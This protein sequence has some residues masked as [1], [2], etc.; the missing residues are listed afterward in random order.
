MKRKIFLNTFLVT[1]FVFSVSMIIT[2]GVLY[3]YYNQQKKLE[4]RAEASY[5]CA[6]IEEN[7]VQMLE[8]VNNH[9]QTEQ[10]FRVTLMSPDGTVLYDSMM[11]SASM[12][13]HGQRQEFTE[14]VETGT[15]ESVR[16][17]ETL[18]RRTYNYA[19]A[20]E[21]GNVLRISGEQFTLIS[22]LVNMIYPMVLLILLV[23]LLSVIMAERLSRSVMEP[24]NNLEVESPMERDIYPELR[25]LVQRIN[26]Q[27]RQLHQQMTELREEHEKQDRMRREFTANV[28]HELKTPLTSISGYAEILGAGIVHGEDV[29][30]F[31]G[32]IYDEAQR[33]ITL[34]G[35]IIDLSQLEDGDI[36]NETAEC[37]LYEICESVVAHLRDVAE[38][39]QVNLYL[40][41]TRETVQGVEKILEEMVF[42][43][44]DNA[45]KYNREQGTVEISV[46]CDTEK[47]VCLT[48]RDTGIGIPQEELPRIFE[49][50]YRVDKSH[51]KEVG[52][53]G[54]GLSIVKHGASY[55]GATIEIDSQLDKGT[56][57]IIRFPKRCA[58]LT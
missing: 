27:N 46:A 15:G 6:V 38:R 32:K 49:R 45:I 39:K 29:G 36:E 33:L 30:R 41:G 48:V 13:N 25:P 50:F 4:F 11:D 14:A 53:T 12:E 58:D 9:S 24:I 19:V 31:S 16:Y 18:A 56:S 26:A 57:I 3:H 47:Q 52:G 54:L 1:M 42:N 17:S 22:L 5:L 40:S 34:V 43:L 23:L 37:N 35:D 10:V 20:L 2:M 28:S 44:V 51:S 7:G 55:H 21:D 8:T